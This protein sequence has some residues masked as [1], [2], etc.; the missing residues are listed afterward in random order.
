MRSVG[1]VIRAIAIWLIGSR[2]A[3]VR[4]GLTADRRLLGP[5]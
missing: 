2:L 1:L 4:G 5:A 3:P